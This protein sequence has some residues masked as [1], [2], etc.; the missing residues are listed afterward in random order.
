MRK[1]LLLGLLAWC[2]CAPRLVSAQVKADTVRLINP[3][4]STIILF[5][6][7]QN[8]VKFDYN[9]P[10]LELMTAWAVDHQ[11][12]LNVKAAFVTGDLVD[13]NET[14]FPPFPRFGNLSSTEQWQFVSHAFVRLDG[15]IPYFISPGNHEYGYAKAENDLTK[16]PDYFP[17]E[18]NSTWKKMIRASFPNRHGRM[19]MENAAFELNLP[20]WDKLLVVTTE[21]APRDEVLNWIDGLTKSEEF[22]DHQVILLTHSYMTWNGTRIQKEN[23]GVSGANAGQQIWD[24]LLNNSP[25][26]KFVICGHFGIAEEN[27]EYTTGFRQDVNAVNNR[28]TQMMF[29]T[30][31]LGGGWSGNGGDGWIRLLE[32]Q[33]DGKTIAVRTYSPLFGFSFLT[34]QLAWRKASYDEFSF[35]F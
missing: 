2:V 25:N 4:S 6:D 12:S 5:P 30:Q 3:E 14:I 8:Y 28:V 21:F 34:K 23:Y 32:F 11:E 22:Q 18:K 9:Q 16:Y 17:I 7:V 31:T 19:T 10:I 13:Q 33:P 35:Q 15:K 24:K 1:F 26:I 27:Y 20:N 29:N